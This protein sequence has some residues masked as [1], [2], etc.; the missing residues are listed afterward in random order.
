MNKLHV[1]NFSLKDTLECGQTFCWRREGRGYINTDIGQVIYVEQERDQLCYET[2]SDDVSL[3]TLFRLDDPIIEI[4]KEIA[5]DAF[6]RKCIEFAPGLR[7]VSDPFFPCLISFLTSI[8]KNIS[9]IKTMTQIL[10]KKFGPRYKFKGNY[11]YGFPSVDT[12]AKKSANTF[13]NLGFGF[14]SDFIVK[15]SAVISSQQIDS[16]LLK[17][18]GYQ[19]ARQVL[20]TLHGVG[21]K[22]ADCVSLFSLGYLEAFPMDIW[23][24]RVIQ[25]NYDIFSEEGKSYVKKS[26]AARA[27][28]GRYAGYAQQYLF[29]YTRSCGLK[30]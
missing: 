8:W 11:Y 1:E 14:R 4:Q 16:K 9:A 27:Y 10:R 22:V 19:K 23:I 12:L 3:R 17:D 29:H 21:N 2:S 30:Q 18:C 26:N 7:I 15:T 25:H 20:K 6:M 24:E 28:F 5:K 13:R